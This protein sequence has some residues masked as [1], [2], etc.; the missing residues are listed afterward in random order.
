MAELEE[1]VENNPQT[2]Y[3]QSDWPIGTI[4]LI[5]AVIFIMLVILKA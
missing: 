5:L 2:A 1:R 4:G 3:E